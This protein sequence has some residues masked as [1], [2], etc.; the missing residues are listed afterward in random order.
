MP[1][2]AK[3]NKFITKFMVNGQRPTKMHD[4]REEGEAWELMARAAIKLGKPIPDTETAKVGGKD[5]STVGGA[6]R[7]A[8]LK[9]WAPKGDGSVKT[10]VNAEVFTRWCGPQMPAEEAFSQEKVDEFFE[11]LRTERRVSNT[12]INKYRSAISVMLEY[13]GLDEED[14]PELPWLEQGAG[15]TRVF[16]EDETRMIPQQWRLWNEE[17]YADFFMFILQTGA[18]PFIDAKRLAWANVFEPSKFQPIP[19]VHFMEAKNGNA[20]TVPLP[21]EAYEAL[22]RQPLAG[23]GPWS[24][25]DKDELRRL[26][27]RTRVAFPV[28]KDAV[29]YTCRHTYC[30]ELYRRTRD[31][32]LVKDMAGHKN[33]KT[34]E[35][36]VK[37]V[38]GDSFERVAE[39]MGLGRGAER[40]RLTV[41]GGKD[42]V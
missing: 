11:Y 31:I 38:G 3:G 10:C 37:I 21:K 41:L 30:T 7:A 22:K 39:V 6:L 35:I 42:E 17:R 29:L 25:V 20:R 12:T 36:Y 33:Y 18:R 5:S 27:D 28:L 26:W 40:P 2:Y 9:R 23:T 32:K 24:W 34:T 19:A 4:T 1:T 13:S 8:K 14:R 15:R 16:T